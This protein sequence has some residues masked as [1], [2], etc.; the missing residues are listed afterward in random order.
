MIRRNHVL[1]TTALVAAL[2]LGS[3]PGD[4]AVAAPGGPGGCPNCPDVDHDGSVGIGDL[5]EMLATHG[6]CGVGGTDHADGVCPADID[7]DGTVGFEDL[8]AIL[9]NWG[10]ADC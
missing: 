8:L 5:L 1:G 4:P 10:P 6:P 3:A 2:A 9:E 7:C